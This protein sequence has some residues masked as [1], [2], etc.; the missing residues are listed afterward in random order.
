MRRLLAIAVVLCTLPGMAWQAPASSTPSADAK[1]PACTLQGSVVSMVG[2]TPVRKANVR[3]IPQQPSVGDLGVTT[4]TDAEGHFSFENLA[5]GR[6]LLMVTHSSFVTLG[7][8]GSGALSRTLAYTLAPGQ[9]LKD[10]LVRLAP[11]AVVR[12]R[13]T[14]EDGDPVTRA[15]VQVV[16]VDASARRQLASPS[17]TTDD[18]GEYRVFSVPPGRYYLKATPGFDLSRMM[19]GPAKPEARSYIPTFYPGTANRETAAPVDL[20]A[21]DEVSLNLTLVRGA[22]YTVAGM[23]KNASGAPVVTGMVMVIQS[24]SPAGTTMVKEGK[25]ELR[26]PPGRYTLMGMGMDEGFQPGSLPTNVHRSIVV[27]EAGLRDVDMVLGGSTGPG[28]VAGRVRAESG[29]LPET[30]RLMLMLRPLKATSEDEDDPF[31][32]IGGGFATAKNDGTFELN[33]VAP[34]SYELVV[35]TTARGLEDW[36]TRSVIVGGRDTVNSGLTV[37]GSALQ[38]DVVLSPAGATLEGVVQDRDQH[39]VPNSIVVLVPDASRSQHRSLYHTTTTDQGGRF[40]L[41][42]LEP[43]DYTVYAWDDI[44]DETWFNTEA[45]RRYK[46]DGVAASVRASERKQIQLRLIVNQPPAR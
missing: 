43:G 33:N 37:A 45:M 46:D 6:Y 9:T 20:R 29:A 25:F 38:L 13:V 26:L 35:S 5:A 10:V 11:A 16:S 23:L 27:T 12:G 22:V 24:S 3:L 30:Q 15:A 4:T 42:G 17:A 7:G 8:S 44:E 1:P 36:Y 40:Q 41:R 2:A 21:G 18:Q 31:S 39:P 34:G 28:H 19:A 14:D 32:A